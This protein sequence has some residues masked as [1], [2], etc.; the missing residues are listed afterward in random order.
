LE[1]AKNGLYGL[2]DNSFVLKPETKFKL[3][4]LDSENYTPNEW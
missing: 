1:D 2:F 3:L 4:N